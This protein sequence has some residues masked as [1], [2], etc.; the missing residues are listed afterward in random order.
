MASRNQRIPYVRD[1]KLHRFDGTV[2]CA[3][4]RR[5]GWLD[6]LRGPGHKSF[7]FENAAGGLTCTLV[8]ERRKSAAGRVHHY[9]YAHKR[10][11][12]KLRRKYIGK[13]ET[14]DLARLEQ[15]A[16]EVNQ[17]AFAVD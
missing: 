5:T 11:D 16:Q 4:G 1:G 12:G 10:I 15:A 6:W 17:L 9:W 8:K 7:Q 14:L 3:V 13:S 2:V